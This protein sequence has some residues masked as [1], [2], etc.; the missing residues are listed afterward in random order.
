MNVWMYCGLPT[1]AGQIRAGAC[2]SQ[3]LVDCYET[4]DGQPVLNLEQPYLDSDHLKPNYNRDNTI[5][6]TTDPYANRD[7][8]FYGSIYYNGALRYLDGRKDQ[9]ET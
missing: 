5:Y 2:P 3:E 7:P 1:T 9:V 8:R 6:N 4:T